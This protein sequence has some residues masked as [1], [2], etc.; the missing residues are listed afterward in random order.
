[1]STSALRARALRVVLRG[2]FTSRRGLHRR[3]L[4]PAGVPVMSVEAGATTGWAKYAHAHHGLD[5]FGV[6]AKGADAMKHF[7][8]TPENI[9]AKANKVA[10]YYAENPVPTIPRPTF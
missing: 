10:A 2:A 7:G 8:F 5:E 3:S 6:S 4:F 1:M 9:A